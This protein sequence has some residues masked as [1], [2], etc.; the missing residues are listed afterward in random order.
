MGRLVGLFKA[1]I[2]G[3]LTI[4]ALAVVLVGAVLIVGM[5]T[6]S[7]TVQRA[8]RQMNKAFWN[9]RAMETA[10]T[11][12][13]HAAVVHHIGR[14]SG[15]H[16]ETPA[17]PA[18]T[19]DGFAIALP[20]G[21]RADWVQNVLAAGTAKITHDG[22]TVAVDRP[23]IVPIGSVHASFSESERKA[24]RAFGVDQCLRLRLVGVGEPPS[25]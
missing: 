17:T 5:R 4:G 18:K 13:A 3:V 8:V 24:H 15:A 16:Y 2:V 22:E 12:G 23:E 6:K 7:P 20:Y 21:L 11:P 10:G 14:R 9:P 1:L 19:D 25:A